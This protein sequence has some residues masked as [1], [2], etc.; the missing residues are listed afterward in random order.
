MQ[1]STC[2]PLHPV[3]FSRPFPTRLFRAIVGSHIVIYMYTYSSVTCQVTHVLRVVSAHI[4]GKAW[5]CCHFSS[6]RISIIVFCFFPPLNIAPLRDVGTCKRWGQGFWLHIVC[7]KTCLQLS[8]PKNVHIVASVI[9][10]FYLIIP[11]RYWVGKHCWCLRC[12]LAWWTS[13]W[14]YQWCGWDKS[15]VL[16]VTE[17]SQCAYSGCSLLWRVIASRLVTES[18]VTKRLRKKDIREFGVP[19]LA[20]PFNGNQQPKSKPVVHN[21]LCCAI[22]RKLL[23]STS[24]IWW[25]IFPYL[26]KPMVKTMLCCT[27][28]IWR[29]IFPYLW[30]PMVKVSH[31]FSLW[32]HDLHMIGLY[33]ES[34]ITCWNVT[35]AHTHALMLHQLWTWSIVYV[36]SDI[37]NWNV[38]IACSIVGCMNL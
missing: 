38:S 31:Q 17:Y 20:G 18:I 22:Q 29:E 25:E 27:S 30:R 15:V 16:Q 13:L 28:N 8:T 11:S 32:V 23:C 10:T 37:K 14:A 24:D 19:Y 1:Y 26:W 2:L 7:S 6:V 35:Y 36:S 9:G 5:W 4:L 3:A 34:T 21:C 12:G 33:C